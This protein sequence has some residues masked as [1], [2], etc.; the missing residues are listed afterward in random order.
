MSILVFRVP[1]LFF[2]EIIWQIIWIRERSSELWG[3]DGVFTS[4]CLDS[5]G[6]AES[7]SEFCTCKYLVIWN[8]FL[9][10][11]IRNNLH[12]KAWA[13]LPW[14]S[15]HQ[16]ISSA[17]IVSSNCCLSFAYIVVAI[18][19]SISSFA[20]YVLYYY[21]IITWYN[22]SLGYLTSQNMVA[23]LGSGESGGSVYIMDLSGTID[24]PTVSLD[25]HG[26]LERVASFDRT[27]YTADCNLDGTQVVLGELAEI[28]IRFMPH[29][30]FP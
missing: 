22:I 16:L 23:T 12:K 15:Q 4:A 29:P 30:K 11:L 7:S 21:S 18:V 28:G 1:W 5:L 14:C 10:L 17:S 25:A 20:F 24:F 26:R 8:S 27:V 3:R 6:K 9:E 13:Q 19:T 2:S